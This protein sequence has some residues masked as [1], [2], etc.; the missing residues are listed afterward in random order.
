MQVNDI[1]TFTN[2][3]IEKHRNAA[4]NEISDYIKSDAGNKELSIKNIT[5][6]ESLAVFMQEKYNEYVDA[7]LLG[8]QCAE[9]L[10]TDSGILF[11]LYDIH[12]FVDKSGII[13]LVW[14]IDNLEYH[15]AITGTAT[16]GPFYKVFRTDGEYVIDGF[17]N[18]EHELDRPLDQWFVKSLR[19]GLC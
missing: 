7:I 14:V 8:V 3:H 6:N 2:I 10:F 17:I 15:F 1:R 16:K 18:G 4:Y 12:D 13:G 11:R 19:K 5:D 9:K